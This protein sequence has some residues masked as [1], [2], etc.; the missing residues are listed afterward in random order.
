MIEA[1]TTLT[2]AGL[3]YL[4]IPIVFGLGA[5][6]VAMIGTNVGAGQ[7]AR[8]RRI[9]WAGGL[10]AAA[11]SG[12]IG[13]TVALAPGLWAGIF[14][15]DKEVLAIASQYL[16]TAGPA[17]AFLGLGMALYFS[18]QGT[19]RMLW[20]LT[21]VSVRLLVIALGCTLVTQSP[22]LGIGALF[23]VIAVA[24][25]VFGAMYAIG[26]WRFFPRR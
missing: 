8:A 4:Q 16:R 26:V 25:V 1:T 7:M 19:G 12:S 2:R 17:Y 23:A 3:E 22:G 5:T 6:L 21:C 11:V 14:T 13:L 20:P 15:Q 18:F 24:L 9:A 10:F